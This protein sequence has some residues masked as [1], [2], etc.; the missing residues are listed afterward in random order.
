M[1]SNQEMGYFTPS[2][3]NVFLHF[4]DNKKQ[5][6]QFWLEWSIFLLLIKQTI[7]ITNQRNDN[8]LYVTSAK[9]RQQR[10]KRQK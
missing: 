8:F 6:K 10:D 4:F 9:H 1:K 5:T 3:V 2:R 7:V